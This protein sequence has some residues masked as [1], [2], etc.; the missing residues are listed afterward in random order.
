M[1][2]LDQQVHRLGDEAKDLEAAAHGE[3]DGTIQ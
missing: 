1:Q 3:E 2:E